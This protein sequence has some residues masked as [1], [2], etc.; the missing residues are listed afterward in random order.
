MNA[1]KQLIA[2]SVGVLL[3]PVLWFSHVAYV[4]AQ[5]SELDK[6]QQDIKDRGSRLAEIEKEIAKFESELKEVGAEKQ[7]LQ[8]AINQLNLERKKVTAEISKTENFNW[9]N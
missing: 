3:T 5:S 2:F 4:Q 6:L 7:T 8:K 9:I 1:K